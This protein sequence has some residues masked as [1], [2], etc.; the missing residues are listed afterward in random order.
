MKG[1]VLQEK[2]NEILFLK[3]LFQKW[4]DVTSYIFVL[5]AAMVL[6]DMVCKY[7]IALRIKPHAAAK[8][9]NS[10]RHGSLYAVYS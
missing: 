7:Q 1:G 9:R 5:L 6:N 2:K 8:G 10:V 4:K 3:N